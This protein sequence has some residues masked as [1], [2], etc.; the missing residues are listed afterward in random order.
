MHNCFQ[1]VKNAAAFFTCFS[2]GIII[3]KNEREE[4]ICQVLVVPVAVAAEAAAVREVLEEAPEGAVLW[5]EAP[6]GAVPWAV[7]AEVAPWVDDPE[8]A[9]RWAVT[10]PLH[11]LLW[12]VTDPHRLPWAAEWAGGPTAG[13]WAAAAV[14]RL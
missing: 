11:H 7:A 9:D 3:Q 10:D 13:R 4:W 2:F 14:C 12:A 8:A 6:E 1:N 5:A